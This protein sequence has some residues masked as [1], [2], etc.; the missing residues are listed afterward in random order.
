MIKK[1][2][3]K[4]KDYNIIKLYDQVCDRSNLIKIIL[5]LPKVYLLLVIHYLTYLTF[6]I[7]FSK[8]LFELTYTINLFNQ[9]I[10]KLVVLLAYGTLFPQTYVYKRVYSY[11]LSYI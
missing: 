11:L 4:L 3:L 1:I 10:I 7:N 5:Y 2:Y 8:Q 9:P 6:S